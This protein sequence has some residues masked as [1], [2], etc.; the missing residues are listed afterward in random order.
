MRRIALSQRIVYHKGRAYDATEHA[1]YKLLL[2]HTLFFLPNTL[3][4]DFDKIADHVES[5]II[6][7]GDDSTLRRTVE[8]KLA[9]KMMQRNKPVVGVCHGAFLLGETLGCTIQEIPKHMD[10]E[11]YIMYH[12]EAIKVTSHHSLGITKMHETGQILCLADTGEVEAFI[13]GKVAGI[14]W[15]P[16]RMEK[17]WIPPEIALLLGI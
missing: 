17:P 10:V 1:W 12:G 6:T 4:Q 8:L 3:D 14:V 13:D 11:H 16:E 2:G 15:H 5:F 9:G 7:G